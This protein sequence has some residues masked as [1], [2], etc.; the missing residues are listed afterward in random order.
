MLKMPEMA[1]PRMALVI[2]GISVPLAALLITP[3]GSRPVGSRVP[4]QTVSTRVGDL[5]RALEGP[6]RPRRALPVLDGAVGRNLH[7]SAARPRKP[8]CRNDQNDRNPPHSGHFDHF[9]HFDTMLND[10]PK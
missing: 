7:D 2:S 5:C 4:C 3:E 8:G 9:G 1:F 6:H 10:V